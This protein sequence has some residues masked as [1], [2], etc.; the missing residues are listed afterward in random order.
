[1]A[2]RIRFHLDEHIAYAVAV[3]LRQ[4]GIDV[5]TTVEAGLRTRDD[6]A[7][8]AF[9]C[10]EQ[11]FFVTNDAGFLARHARGESHFGIAY[12]PVNSRSIGGVVTFLTLIYEILTA[13]ETVNQVI[14]L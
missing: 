11:R 7:Q 2:S 1:M 6:D 5:T 8:I 14:Y 10:Q 4:R 12:Y 9:V 13:E 3:G